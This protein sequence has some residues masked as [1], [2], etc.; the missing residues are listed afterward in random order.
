MMFAMKLALKIGCTLRELPQRMDTS[1][2][3]LWLAFNQ[4][5]P[6]GDERQDI[7]SAIVAHAAVLPHIK[8]GSNLAVKDFIPNWSE[9]QKRERV[10][11]SLVSRLAPFAVKPN[12]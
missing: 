5:S 1:E 6:I 11:E 3:R 12:G 9:D 10:E 4:L 7:T 8:R 2:F